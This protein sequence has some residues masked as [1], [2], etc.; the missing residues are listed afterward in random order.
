MD[1]NINH[2]LTL[3]N[4]NKSSVDVRVKSKDAE[5]NKKVMVTD[6]IHLNLVAGRYKLHFL[7]D[8]LL[9]DLSS[10]DHIITIPIEKKESGL[11]KRYIFF[12]GLITI[13]ITL[14]IIG[15]KNLTPSNI[16]EEKF[17]EALL[18]LQK[19]EAAYK[20]KDYDLAENYYKQS[21]R[22]YPYYTLAYSDLS[23]LYFRKGEYQKAINVGEEG[24]EKMRK[25]I[26]LNQNVRSNYRAN[27]YYNIAISYDEKGN[28]K[29][30]IKY[31]QRSLKLRKNKIVEDRLASV[32]AKLN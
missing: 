10:I 31:I 11:I 14:L 32:R 16:S 25:D 7:K 28:S 30:A 23:L 29:K 27:L 19:G 22:Y 5:Y 21:L 12:A 9:V 15:V 2:T 24:L 20:K 6:E 18:Y 8:E 3:I 17:E 13:L 4:P 1:E 26:K